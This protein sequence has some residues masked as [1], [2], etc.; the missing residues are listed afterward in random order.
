MSD[1]LPC[2]VRPEQPGDA[3]DVTRIHE[4]AFPTPDEARLVALLRENGKAQVSL[5]AV[6]GGRVVGHILFS[7]VTID[8]WPIT[9]SGLAPVAVLPDCQGRGVGS[10]LVRAGLEAC[11]ALGMP[12]A[13][14]LGGPGYYRRF[15]F[16]RA[17]EQG[18]GNEYSVDEEFMVLE[19]RPGSLP[20][21]GGL[22]RYAPEFAGVDARPPADR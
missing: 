19:L 4:A 1:P 16:E 22:V 14:V 20:P 7:P 2:D 18:L 11:R 15:G 13:V 6:S 12:F 21:E 10:R 9:G 17:S 5:V 8:D 3:A